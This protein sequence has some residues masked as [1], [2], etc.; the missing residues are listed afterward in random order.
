MVLGPGSWFTSVI[1]H[2]MV[3]ELRRALVQTDGRV[4]LVLN[5]DEQEGETPGFGPAD[6]LAG[7]S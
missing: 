5:L 2:L 6:H 1:P 3:P 4:V 7:R